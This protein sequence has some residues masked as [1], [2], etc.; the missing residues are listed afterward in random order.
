MCNNASAWGT[1]L[2]PHRPVTFLDSKFYNNAFSANRNGHVDSRVVN[3]ANS[4]LRFHSFTHANCLS[5]LLFFVASLF[6]FLRAVLVKGSSDLKQ[7]RVWSVE[8]FFFM[9][10]FAEDPLRRC[11]RS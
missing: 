8:N 5:R 10:G 9:L 7:S 6:V 2:L 3:V 1:C 4:R 11:L